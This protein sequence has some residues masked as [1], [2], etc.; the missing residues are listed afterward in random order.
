MV[1][2]EK[3][4][5]SEISKKITLIQRKFKNCFCLVSIPFEEVWNSF[6]LS[7]PP[8]NIRI[9]RCQNSTPFITRIVLKIYNEMADEEKL[10]L[11]TQYFSFLQSSM[12]SSEVAKDIMRTQLLNLKIP[13][14]DCQLIMEGMPSIAQIMCATKEEMLENCPVELE[15]ILKLTNFFSSED[16][17]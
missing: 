14:E 11:Q 13:I 16:E 2:D 10:Q 6:Q 12:F 9:V 15:S 3:V 1:C 17:S 7:I 5:L 8:G 4:P